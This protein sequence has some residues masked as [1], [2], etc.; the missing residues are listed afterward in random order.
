[1]KIITKVERKVDPDTFQQYVE[2]T[3]R[4]GLEL[5]QDLKY[6]EEKRATIINEALTEF[7]E[8]YHE[9]MKKE[10]LYGY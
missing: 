7:E 10:N 5:A 6:H 1:M 9:M 4:F 3:A 2:V 8:I